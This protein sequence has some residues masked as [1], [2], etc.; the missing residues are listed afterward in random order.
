MKKTTQNDMEK[1]RNKRRE[2]NI[3]SIMHARRGR[4]RRGMIKEERIERKCRKR[5]H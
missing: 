1:G 3:R 4:A 2:G 5:N